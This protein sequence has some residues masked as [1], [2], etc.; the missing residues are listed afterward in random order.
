M[1]RICALVLL[2]GVLLQHVPATAT[3][4]HQQPYPPP[5]TT[6]AE[7][8]ATTS[9]TP[10]ATA[11]STPEP[12][13]EPPPPT[14]WV[15]TATPPAA[16]ATPTVAVPLPDA[17]EPNNAAGVAAPITLGS[18]DKLSFWPL[19][20]SDWFA[21]TIKPSQAGLT[22]TVDTFITAGLDTQLQLFGPD[23]A[24]AAQNDVSATDVRASLATRVIS[25]G[26]YL[27]SVANVAQARPDFKTYQLVTALIDQTPSPAAPVAPTTPEERGADAYAGNYNWDFAPAIP[28]GERLETLTFGCPAFEYLD[29]ATCVVPDFFRIQVK[30]GQ[31]Y[32]AQT[33]DLAAGID[34][35]L[36]V[37]GPERDQAAPRGGSDDAAH[38]D[39]SSAVTFCVPPEAGVRDAYLLI[40]QVGNRPPPAPIGERTYSLLVTA[41]VPAIPRGS[42]T[43][44]PLSSPTTAPAGGAAGGGTTGGA[45]STGNGGSGG[46]GTDGGPGAS[47][48][49]PAAPANPADGD[50]RVIP[51]PTER[52]NAGPLPGLVV[53]EIP[54]TE[55]EQPT[56]IPQRGV[57]LSLSACYDRNQNQACDIDEGIAGLS[58]YVTDGRSGAVLGQALTD[59][60]GQAALTVRVEDTAE[61][62][63]SV[64]SFAATQR[65][66]AQSPRTRPVMVKTVTP[67][68]AL[69]P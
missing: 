27:I 34:T 2:V 52:P 48:P 44:T 38:G 17:Y 22:L 3:T 28:V 67:L 29:L 46:M 6:T 23:G 63:V 4:V 36:I 62:I 8:T 37:Y 25:P 40:G 66:T 33:Q 15:V 35:N 20:D 10:T 57:P 7:P 59:P 54:L 14:P 12:T 61:L 56:S 24:L 49:P 5:A 11:T 32:A 53:E 69:L 55:A 58:V 41:L 42:P 65:I 50:G 19:G 31:C 9:L 39:F 21:L 18:V 64:P 45:P 43:P 16:T 60:S 26:T 47:V 13:D 51:A 30:G 1:P 68:P